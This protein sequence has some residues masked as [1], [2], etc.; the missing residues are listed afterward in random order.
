[1]SGG[2]SRARIFLA[3]H[4]GGDEFFDGFFSAARF[5]EFV[6]VFGCLKKPSD[7]HVLEDAHHAGLGFESHKAGEPGWQF[8]DPPGALE[9]FPHAVENV[10]QFEAGVEV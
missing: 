3:I 5:E 10:R 1:M 4:A 7:G 9:F 2:G 6:G 8:R